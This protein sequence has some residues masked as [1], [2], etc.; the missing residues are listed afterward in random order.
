MVSTN[1]NLN[2]AF[3]LTLTA[4]WLIYYNK[5]NVNKRKEDRFETPTW[6]PFSH[7]LVDVRTNNVTS[8]LGGLEKF[9]N[10]TFTSRLIGLTADVHACMQATS[11]LSLVNT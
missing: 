2:R 10:V 6:P 5:K 9:S 4:V 8:Q 7:K 11:L 1:L 3:S